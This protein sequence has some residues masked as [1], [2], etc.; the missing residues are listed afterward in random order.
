MFAA[1]DLFDQLD[2]SCP[3]SVDALWDHMEDYGDK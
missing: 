3:T 1:A 2:T